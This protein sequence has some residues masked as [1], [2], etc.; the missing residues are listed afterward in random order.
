MNKFTLALALLVM[1]AIAI[2]PK[3]KASSSTDVLQLLLVQAQPESSEK[4][5]EI[6]LNSGDLQKIPGNTRSGNTR[7]A[8][9]KVE[10][11]LQKA[12]QSYD[13]GDYKRAIEY[14]TQ[15]LKI[16]PNNGVAYSLRSFAYFQLKKYKET[17]ADSTKAIQL[18][19]NNYYA[20]YVRGA[21][22]FYVNNKQKA[23]ADYQKAIK[24]AEQAK[25]NTFAQQARKELEQIRKAG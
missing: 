7:S 20:Y 4:L 1:G 13:S 15:I 25:D 17:I 6:K 8:N 5:P 16:D 23:I 22:H 2:S 18:N 21:S 11:L 14:C 3:A 24:L 10:G 19:P 12:I 9:S